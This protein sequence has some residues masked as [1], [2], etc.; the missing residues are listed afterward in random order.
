VPRPAYE[1]P[2]NLKQVIV[3]HGK[4]G[5]DSSGGRVGSSIKSTRGRTWTRTAMVIRTLLSTHPGRENESVQNILE[6]RP[7]EAVIAEIIA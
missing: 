3:G 1:C 7:D 2:H 4:K 6:L 5:K